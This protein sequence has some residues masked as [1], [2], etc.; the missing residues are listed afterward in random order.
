MEMYKSLPTEYFRV[1]TYT[2][3]L[4]K[5]SVKVSAHVKS[6]NTIQ[7]IIHLTC[8]NKIQSCTKIKTL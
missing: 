8:K 7:Y 3:Q 4:R 5:T 6:A 2:N 1:E